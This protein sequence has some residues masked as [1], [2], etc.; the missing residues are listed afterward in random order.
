MDF[1]KHDAVREEIERA[2]GKT[3]TK[4]DHTWDV[5]SVLIDNDR[6]KI[7]EIVPYVEV[8]RSSVSGILSKLADHGVVTKSNR[9]RSH[10][11][12]LN[13][14]GMKDLI[15]QRQKREEMSELKSEVRG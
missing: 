15:Q 8:S 11:Y 12:A 13:I 9:G 14:D 2:A 1:L 4:E 5:I 3:K 7:D 10:Y 6:V